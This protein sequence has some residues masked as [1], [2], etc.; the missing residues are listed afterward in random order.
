VTNLSSEREFG[1]IIGSLDV[2]S[3]IMADKTNRT[4]VKIIQNLATTIFLPVKL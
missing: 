3:K 1:K 2:L 4:V